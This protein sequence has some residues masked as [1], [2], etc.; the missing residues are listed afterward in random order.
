MFTEYLHL[1]IEFLPI[2]VLSLTLILIRF[3]G[4][5]HYHH[6]TLHSYSFLKDGSYLLGFIM[7]IYWWLDPMN[8]FMS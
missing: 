4:F 7:S 8:V 6:I 5:I 1:W 3:L 2:F